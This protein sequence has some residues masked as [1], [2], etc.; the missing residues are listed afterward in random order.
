MNIGI[1]RIRH[2]EGI[3]GIVR[4]I[5]Y[6]HFWTFQSAFMEIGDC[7]FAQVVSIRD[8]IAKG[9]KLDKSDREFHNRNKHLVDFKNK[10]SSTEKDLIASLT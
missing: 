8:K 6:L 2:K 3:L 5:D 9:K 7:T 1:I 4:E 10:Y